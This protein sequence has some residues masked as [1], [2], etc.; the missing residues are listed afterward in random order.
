MNKKLI[1]L[2]PCLFSLLACGNNE[3]SG[4]S[5][6]NEVSISEEEGIARVNY[7]E[8]H[9]DE[10]YEG[11]DV[12]IS[13]YQENKNAD[14]STPLLVYE[15]KWDAD[16]KIYYHYNSSDY[17]IE[18]EL[19][20]Y[21]E[22]SCWY[23][24][25]MEIFIITRKNYATGE[26]TTTKTFIYSSDAGQRRYDRYVI[27]AFGYA[28][29]DIR[30]TFTDNPSYYGNED[31]DTLIFEGENQLRNRKTRLVFG[32][33]RLYAYKYERNSGSESSSVSY[34][35]EETFD[36]PS[37]VDIALPDISGDE[38]SEVESSSQ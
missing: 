37:S 27:S 17:Y 20:S 33:G 1:V 24:S 7:L 35:S 38:W 31:M 16:R 3:S 15:E 4:Y 23:T 32:E 11:R 22:A 12:T 2:L 26:E 19:D 13:G 36:Y 9:M 30:E 25:E 10:A 34:L 14:A 18:G 5:K 6:G 28:I 29:E 21:R 8:E